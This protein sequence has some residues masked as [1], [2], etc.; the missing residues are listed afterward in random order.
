MKFCEEI[1]KI[2]NPFISKL[3]NKKKKE[4]EKT[5]LNIEQ[6]IL[7]KSKKQKKENY[8]IENDI[9]FVLSI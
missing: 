3:E 7:D 4:K 2:N 9:S 8:K 6:N 5:I 1:I